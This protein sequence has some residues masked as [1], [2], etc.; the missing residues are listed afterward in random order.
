RPGRGADVLPLQGPLQLLRHRP[1]PESGL[2][3]P[4]SVAG[5]RAVL[6]S[7]LLRARRG[8]RPPRRQAARSGT[9]SD[10]PAPWTRPGPRPGRDPEPLTTGVLRLSE[11]TARARLAPSPRRRA[12]RCR[13]SEA[14]SRTRGGQSLPATE[15]AG[16]S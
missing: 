9:R 4:A 16:D 15:A 12:R 11:L 14:R 6:Q 13:P 3:L 10:G 1:A 5:G 2:V 7:R 8:G